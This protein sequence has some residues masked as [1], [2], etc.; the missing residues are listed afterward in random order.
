MTK[1]LCTI[2]TKSKKRKQHSRKAQVK[3]FVRNRQTNHV[4]KQV[5][6]I[7]PSHD[8]SEAQLTYRQP[9]VLT[10]VCLFLSH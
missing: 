8:K 10:G 3:M 1:V 5:P 2:E 7:D 6:R 9:P 4:Y